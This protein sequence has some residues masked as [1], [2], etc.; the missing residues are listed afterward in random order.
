MKREE[1]TLKGMSYIDGPHNTHEAGTSILVNLIYEDGA[2]RPLCATTREICTTALGT[3]LLAIHQHGGFTHLIT[4]WQDTDH[5]WHY[6]WTDNQ[7][8]TQPHPITA[9]AG[10]LNAITA[11]GA[12]LCLVRDGDT[13]YA[14]WDDETAAYHVFSRSDLL[15]DITLTQSDATDATVTMPLSTTYLRQDN[16]KKELQDLDNAIDNLMAQQGD[17]LH[18]HIAIGIAALRLFDGSLTLYSNIFALI[19]PIMPKT[20]TVDAEGKALQYTLPFHR[21]YLTATMRQ[22]DDKLLSL[23]QGIDIFLTEP[24]TLLDPTSIHITSDAEENPISV[25]FTHLT[26][27][28]TMKQLGEMK[29]YKTMTINRD[30]FGI[31][32][33]VKRAVVTK[34]V[35]DLSDLRQWSAGGNHAYSYDNRLHIAAVRQTIH[36]PFDIG[37]HYVYPTRDQQAGGRLADILPDT[38]G[39]SEG[40]TAEVVL[41][42]FLTDSPGSVARFHTQTQYPL[43]G[44]LM[45]PCGGAYRCQ[46]HVRLTTEGRQCQYTYDTP[47][48]C[49]PDK[50]FSFACYQPT[51][52][53][54]NN[55]RPAYAT[56]L[57]Q[58]SRDIYHD[59]FDDS[60]TTAYLLWQEETAEQFD[61][62][63]AQASDQWML[64]PQQGDIRSSLPGNPL[65][66]PAVSH[67]NV[68][69]TIS[70]IATNTRRSA[71][72]QFGDCQYYLFTN[73]GIWVLKMNTTGAWKAHQ[74]V[75]RD[76]L[77]APQ[78]I[79]T[80]SQAVAFMSQRGLLLLR[81]TVTENLSTALHGCP[82]PLHHLPRIDDILQATTAKSPHATTCK[83]PQATT[84]KCPQATT[85]KSPQAT[86]NITT[87]PSCMPQ[88]CCGLPLSPTLLYDTAHQ[89][90]IISGTPSISTLLSGGRGAGGEADPWALV[91]S[92]TSNSWSIIDW[93]YRSAITHGSDIYVVSDQ[94]A[95]S[96]NG[97]HILKLDFHATGS[98]PVVLCSQPLPMGIPHNLKRIYRA[99][100]TGRFIKPSFTLGTALYG[101]NDLINWHLLGASVGTNLE[102]WQGTPFRWFRLVVAGNLSKC[103]RIE[104]LTWLKKEK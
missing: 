33:A 12:I 56:L 58:Q 36:N 62:E 73:Q 34:E 90:L 43:P 100:V 1:I 104:G 75:A 72:G 92:L 3:S 6:E 47:L 89:R 76:V 42:I 44:M 77:A 59:T 94:E 39:H 103:E 83:S 53:P 46:I 50:G 25:S 81:G 91:Y 80:T 84:D 68:G 99:E 96:H 97:S 40:I 69:G 24:T 21:H 67:T 79:A 48:Q 18:K 16:G 30:S 51:G 55:S 19:P 20:L 2:L 52:L 38:M 27:Q 45:I 4:E 8:D 10:R 101:S 85:A 15:Y 28:A 102:T 49:H 41:T 5:Q 61:I 88:P 64:T 26:A 98:V 11:V 78:A 35:L 29:F 66:L 9:T 95:E 7:E 70:A 74:A 93:P 14:L 54:H 71:D 22:A 31:P 32:K 57:F 87:L 13:L 63:A 82:F 37:M 65:V 60:E 17:T 86:S 23:L